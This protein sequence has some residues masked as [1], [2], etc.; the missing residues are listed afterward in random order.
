MH[1]FQRDCLINLGTCIAPL[2]TGNEGK[3]C[4]S[5]E[6]G[7]PDSSRIQKEIGF[8]QI[9]VIP[10][11]VDERAELHLHPRSGFDVG[12]GNGKS[13]QIEVTG[14]V[15]GVIIDARGRPL[16]FPHEHEQRMKKL[17]EWS[18]ALNVYPA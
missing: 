18:A 7:M 11:P 8:G 12:E 1:V 16:Q 4:I 2:G 14:G 13:V 10:L 9:F 15:V 17:R 6:A 5:V 3:S